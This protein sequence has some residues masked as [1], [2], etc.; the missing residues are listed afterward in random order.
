MLAHVA[1]AAYEATACGINCMAVAASPLF[2]QALRLR[3]PGAPDTEGCARSL[4]ERRLRAKWCSLAPFDAVSRSFAEMLASALLPGPAAAIVQA[5]A[6]VD[7]DN[8]LTVHLRG[9]DILKHR[10]GFD[11]HPAPCS[12][13]ADIAAT[14]R[15]GGQFSRLLVVS[16]GGAKHPC[17]PWLARELNGS[18]TVLELRSRGVLEDWATLAAARHLALSPSSTFGLSAALANKTR[19]AIFLPTFSGSGIC[20]E[21]NFEPRQVVE[22]CQLGAGSRVYEYTRPSS[23]DRVTWATASLPKAHTVHT[24]SNQTASGATFSASN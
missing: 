19:T 12:F 20:C 15:G 2:A 6:I 18:G 10:G 7:A 24:C 13:Y 8:V 11:Y 23:E 3:V 4:R 5:R 22:L 16:E 9:G 17:V 14:G 21:G 1:Q